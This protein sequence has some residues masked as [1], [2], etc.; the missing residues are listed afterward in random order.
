MNLSTY[1]LTSLFICIDGR[2]MVR[3]AIFQFRFLSC[4]KVEEKSEKRMNK[5]KREKKKLR[6]D[7]ALA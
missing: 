1:L 4:E 2:W 3:V 5:I 6:K 7:M